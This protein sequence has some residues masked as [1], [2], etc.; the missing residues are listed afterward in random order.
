MDDTFFKIGSS[1]KS[2]SILLWFN[3]FSKSGNS[4]GFALT[5][6]TARLLLDQLQEQLLDLDE[7]RRGLAVTP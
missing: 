7:E 6:D 1:R 3:V 2:D 5:L 4:C